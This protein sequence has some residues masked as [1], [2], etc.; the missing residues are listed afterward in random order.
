M[1]IICRLEQMRP[2][3]KFKKN[4]ERNDDHNRYTNVSSIAFSSNSAQL[5]SGYQD[6]KAIQGTSLKIFEVF[7]SSIKCI[8]F[9]NKDTQIVEG[10]PIRDQQLLICDVSSDENVKKVGPSSGIWA[11]EICPDEKF[12]ATIGYYDMNMIK[13]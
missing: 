13:L 7:N 3:L 9:C 1:E 4:W 5:I 10:M 11:F 2:L 12:I 6:G 8:S